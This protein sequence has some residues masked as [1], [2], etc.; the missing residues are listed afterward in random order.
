MNNLVNSLQ[1]QLE[2]ISALTKNLKQEQEDGKLQTKEGLGYLDVKMQLLLSYCIKIVY[3]VSLKLNGK[4][5]EGHP[6]VKDLIEIRTLIEKLQPLDKKLKYQI[7]KLIQTAVSGSDNAAKDPLH[8]KPNAANLVSKTGGISTANDDV[9][10]DEDG[11]VGK[12]V[13]PRLS[14]MYFDDENAK[15]KQK[16]KQEKIQNK[17][18]ESE[19]YKELQDEFSEK[20]QEIKDYSRIFD[21]AVVN[22]KAQMEKLRFEEE[23]YKRL[24]ETKK[25]RNMARSKRFKNEIDDI[26]N[27]GNFTKLANKNSKSRNDEIGLLKRRS[28]LK[29]FRQDEKKASGNNDDSNIK[30]KRSNKRR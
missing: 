18:R 22:E 2:G 10:V 13:P 5:I 12:Y 9:E 29:Q 27:F 6:V 26:A 23:N 4:Q 16:R 15:E 21:R 28:A 3:Y 20:P 11:N 17:L 30:G 7:D 14:A 25:E 8:F 19:I 1:S 24:P